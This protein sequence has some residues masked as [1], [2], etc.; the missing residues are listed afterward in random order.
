MAQGFEFDPGFAPYV[1]AFKGTIEYLYQDI[2]R[3]KNFSQKKMK[4]RQ[5]HKKIL[6]IFD[7][8]LGFYIGCLMWGAYIATQ[9]KQEICNNYCLGNKY[10][11]Y[12]NT[13]ETDYLLKFVAFFQKDMNYYMSEDFK[14][15]ENAIKVLNTYKEFLIINKGFI[16]AKNNTDIKL[17]DNIDLTD[18]ES[19]KDKIDEIISTGDLSKF[20]AYIDNLFK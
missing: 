15:N 5:Y 16:E 19:Y 18:A 8:N 3:F 6:Q 2:N 17:P 1:L 4:F 11:E 10:N 13:S 14:F 9:E 7:N 12:E 20:L